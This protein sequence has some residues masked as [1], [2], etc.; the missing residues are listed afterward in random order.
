MPGGDRKPAQAPG[1]VA[2]AIASMGRGRPGPAALECAIDVWGMRAPVTKASMIAPPTPT[3][4]A[5]I[6]E[7]AIRAAAKRLGGA[8]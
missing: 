3:G 2:A 4:P 5:P 1:L 7:D 6:D 8:S